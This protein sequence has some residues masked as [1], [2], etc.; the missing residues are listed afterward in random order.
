MVA[1]AKHNLVGFQVPQPTSLEFIEM[2]EAYKFILENEDYLNIVM[3]ESG[4]I[5]DRGIINMCIVTPIGACYYVIDNIK[6]E[7]QLAQML[8]ESMKRVHI[9]V[10]DGG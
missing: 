1:T 3:D 6:D 8:F 7:S 4:D 5:A 10:G 9:I 2:L